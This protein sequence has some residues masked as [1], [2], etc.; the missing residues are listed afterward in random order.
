MEASRFTAQHALEVFARLACGAHPVTAE[1]LPTECV[2]REPDVVR[3]IAFART[4]L[5]DHVQRAA[6]RA[7]APRNLG[8]PWTV[9]EELLM[10]SAFDAGHTPREIAVTLERSLAAIEAR[11][12]K[13]GKISAAE[14]TTQDRFRRQPRQLPTAPPA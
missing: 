10:I 1:R 2:T 6:K 14:R 4:A 5:A 12:E 13:V 8:A 9:E 3:A 7:N 11:L